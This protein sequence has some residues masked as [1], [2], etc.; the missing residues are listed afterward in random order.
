MDNSF[1]LH[2]LHHAFSQVGVSFLAGVHGVRAP[3]LSHP[4]SSGPGGG[5]EPHQDSWVHQLR[6]LYPPSLKQVLDLNSHLLQSISDSLADCKLSGIH[7]LAACQLPRNSGDFRGLLF[8][9]SVRLSESPE[10]Y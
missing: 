10:M 6:V 8:W 3:E 5:E 4:L 1:A 7:S 2:L 9:L